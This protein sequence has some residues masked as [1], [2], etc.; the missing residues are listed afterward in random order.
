MAM[1]RKNEFCKFPLGRRPDLYI[2]MPINFNLAARICHK[3]L[4]GR[5]DSRVTLQPIL[6]SVQNRQG[7]VSQDRASSLFKAISH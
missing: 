7:A 3:L 4:G 6:F 5:Y 2:S 1:R